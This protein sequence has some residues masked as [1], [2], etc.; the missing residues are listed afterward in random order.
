MRRNL[1]LGCLLAGAA[2]ASCGKNED[3]A[4]VR[5]GAR[6]IV[7]WDSALD[8]QFFS[9]G[10][11]RASGAE[12]PRVEIPA[13]VFLGPPGVR[14]QEIV[15]EIADVTAEEALTIKVEGLDAKKQVIAVGTAPARIVPRE[16][17]VLSMRL[18]LPSN[19]GPGPDPDPD[20]VDPLP[21][22]NPFYS[23]EQLAPQH[24]ASTEFVDVPGATLSFTP[25]S[26][27]SHWLVMISG[28][29]GSNA[30]AEISA[31]LRLMVNGVE[32]DVFGHQTM[33]EKDNEAGFVSFHPIERAMGVQTIVPQFRA[34]TGTTAVS[35]LRVVAF[36]LPDTADF[37]A[38]TD[39]SLLEM[40][41]TQISVGRL[42]F[43]PSRPGDYLVLAKASQRERPSGATVQTWLEDQVGGRHPF[44]EN[45]ASFSNGR[46][47]WQPIF[48]A[49]RARLD[50]SSASFMLRGTSSGATETIDWWN[51]AWPFRRALTAVDAVGVEGVSIAVT[52]DHAAMVAAGRSRVDGA[53]VRVAAKS[54]EVWEELDRVLDPES[55][56]NTPATK[57]WFSAKPGVA[58]PLASYALYSGNLAAVMPPEDPSAV[59]SFFDDFDAP[60]SP[61]TWSTVQ[62]APSVQNGTLVVPG[63][64]R[65]ATT[66]SFKNGFR[67]DAKIV[68]ELAENDLLLAQLDYFGCATAEVADRQEL[69]FS[70]REQSHVARSFGTNTRFKN[71]S[72]ETAHVYAFDRDDGV[73]FT[74]DGM[75]VAD[76][77]Q[78]ASELEL[79][80]SVNNGS[81]MSV[82]R[83]E[84]VR[85][86]SLD[87]IEMTA[88]AEESVTGSMPSQ[89]S[90]RKIVAFRLD[91]FRAAHFDNSPGLSAS[92][93]D[94]FVAKN[95]ID[96]PAL[97]TPSRDVS[98]QSLR[99]SGDAS[100]TQRKSGVLRA[101]G[102]VLL[103]TSHKLNKSG[104]IVGGYHHVAGVVRAKENTSAVR[105]ENGVR[106][107]DGLNVEGADSTI[108]VLRY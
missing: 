9:A 15:L 31:E 68:L 88:G 95:A 39:E 102:E 56:W 79:P 77:A 6:L 60:L 105:Y 26:A 69:T 21:I 62:G 12:I 59:Y 43:V 101:N 70:V 74:L 92:M 28:L 78:S 33:G 89:W 1:V 97:A 86:M 71:I 3:P 106:S 84:W 44:D 50:T 51:A 63:G 17:S 108:I 19:P 47:P 18:F 96:V 103:E 46:D 85:V 80:I 32:A 81:N 40:S 75:T 30:T 61:Q 48:T 16:L 64:T 24:T 58:D 67:F 34:A 65:I 66:T 55:E 87:S 37:H 93:A 5:T 36:V 11:T 23:V 52:F 38:Y 35:N 82:V 57:I 29:L 73:L 8:P 107:P 14:S 100:D 7:L 20:P 4:R 22:E 94:T 83:I 45:G 53:D 104:S 27:G 99:I 49:M 90:H 13:E 2:L 76:H 54:T 25:E 10:G 72:P 98:I 91:A 41:G 42:A